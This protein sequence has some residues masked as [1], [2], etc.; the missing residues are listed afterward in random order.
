VQSNSSALPGTHPREKEDKLSKTISDD[1]TVVSAFVKNAFEEVRAYF[2]SYKGR[3]LAHIR[4]FVSDDEDV[5]HP[6]KKGVAVRIE[7]LP[8]LAELVGALMQATQQSDTAGS[9][10]GEAEEVLLATQ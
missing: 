8:K 2:A 1:M 7:D 6:T 10:Q 5:M 4:V 9:E 3:D